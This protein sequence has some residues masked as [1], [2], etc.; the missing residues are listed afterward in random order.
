NDGAESFDPA[1]GHGRVDRITA[2]TTDA[3]H[4]DP[5]A[6][7]VRKC[8]QIIGDAPEIFNA[9]CGIFDRARLAATCTLETAVNGDDHKARLGQRLSI[10]I[11]RG[12]FFTTADWVSADDGGIFL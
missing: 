5:V 7:H 9:L 2:T 10:N 11:P 6:V 1:L 12:L 4:A 8:H 3:E